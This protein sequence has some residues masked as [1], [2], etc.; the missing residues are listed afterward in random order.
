MTME[1]IRVR[2]V[3]EGRVQGVWF[4]ES[5]RQEAE[6]LGVRGWVRNRREGTVEVLVEGP[7]ENVRK[8]V[9]W[10]HHGPPSARVG[11]VYETTEMFQGEFASFDVVY[12]H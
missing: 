2:L 3:I 4:R 10:C 1:N 11:R 9:G 5:T 8:L 12:S 6:R 7:E